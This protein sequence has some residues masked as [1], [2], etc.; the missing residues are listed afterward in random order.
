M[1]I[2][3]FDCYPFGIFVQLSG[4]TFILPKGVFS[5]GSL[6]LF[7][8]PGTLYTKKSSQAAYRLRRHSG[9]ISIQTYRIIST[10]IEEI[11]IEKSKA[12]IS[13][14]SLCNIQLLNDS[15]VVSVNKSLYGKVR[16]FFIRKGSSSTI[17][18]YG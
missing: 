7:R 9:E 8:N 1:S 17:Q 14:Y 18:T 13:R 15:H 6:K 12:L 16:L 4:H 11:K 2:L 10:Y 3:S 5:Y